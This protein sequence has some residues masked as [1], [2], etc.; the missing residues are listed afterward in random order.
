MT[1]N[2]KAP[3]TGTQTGTPSPVVHARK[4]SDFVRSLLLVQA[5][6]RCEFDGCNEYPL[7]HPITHTWGSFGQFAHIVAFRE[8]GPRGSDPAR[9]S[10]IHSSDNLMLLC[11]TCHKL[12]DDDPV[13]WTRPVLEGY[14][15]AHE[16][17]TFHV[18][19]L[20]PNRSTTVLVLKSR[21]RNAPVTLPFDQ[22]VAA[23]NPRYPK[24]RTPL[25]ID[26]TSIPDD[27]PGYLDMA[28]ATL[29]RH[30]QQLLQPGSELHSTQHL[31]I[32]ALARIP[33]LVFLGKEL[34]NKVPTD[35]YQRH[36][37]PENWTWR[38]EGETVR[39]DFQKRRDGSPTRIALLIS[40]SGSISISALPSDIQESASIYEITLSGQVPAPTFLRLRQDL[41]NFITAYLQALSFILAEYGFV[42]VID[43]FLAVPAPIAVL[44]G[45]ELLPNV[46]PNLCVYDLGEHGE[47][48]PALAITNR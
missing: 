43:L 34:S 15:K 22:M 45:R 25:E 7:E 21:I 23:T 39:Y 14:K 3:N 38:T 10:E 31:S 36:R 6:G 33:L 26:L 1:Q 13:T 40:L 19:S 28:C 17:R 44:C 47:Y 30:V 9:P 42:E 11:P 20:G 16:E 8:A 24:S 27:A 35:I 37:N 4:I 2:K 48:K 5:G 32:F 29:R 46:H 12:I 18:T 41:T